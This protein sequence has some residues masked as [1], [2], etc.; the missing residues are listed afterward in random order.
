MPPPPFLLSLTLPPP[1][2]QVVICFT[3]LYYKEGL[4][5]EIYKRHRT[6]SIPHCTLSQ[7]SKR[8]PFWVDA[9]D[10]Q[11]TGW[12]SDLLASLIGCP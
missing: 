7:T 10:G 4:V 12:F 8:N 3:N 6:I 5:S 9:E 1:R 2:I 11:G